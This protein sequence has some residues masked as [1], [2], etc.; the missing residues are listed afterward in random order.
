MDRVDRGEPWDRELES[1]PLRLVDQLVTPAGLR[2]P[3]E[4]GRTIDCPIA[5]E[6]FGPP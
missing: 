3:D 4:A 5:P 6:L 1:V 2:T